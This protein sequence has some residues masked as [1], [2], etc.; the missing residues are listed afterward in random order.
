MVGSQSYAAHDTGPETFLNL[1]NDLPASLLTE[2][3]LALADLPK[4]EEPMAANVFATRLAFLAE[5]RDYLLFIADDVRE[6]AAARLI[7]LVT[8]GI[9]PD[10]FCAVLLAESVTLLEGGS[11][12]DDTLSR[13]DMDILITAND[14]F[15]LMRVLEEVTVNSSFAPE[16]YL[17]QL[18]LYIQ[19]THSQTASK[20]AGKEAAL[21]KLEEVRLALARNL[22]RAMVVGFDNPF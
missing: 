6:E 20:L 14:T 5:F 19:R 15:E 3:P 21:F 12:S 22:A 9:A 17:S 16:E 10:G 18:A 11:A 8:S 2:A 7:G 4:E 13:A 1:V